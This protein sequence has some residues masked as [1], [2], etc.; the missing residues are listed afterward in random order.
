MCKIKSSQSTIPFCIDLDKL[1]KS[2][3]T[4]KLFTRIVKGGLVFGKVVF[5]GIVD[6]KVFFFE[7][8]QDFPML[9]A[10]DRDVAGCFDTKNAPLLTN[11]EIVAFFLFPKVPEMIERPALLQKN[12]CS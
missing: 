6:F 8:T 5:P 10:L 3:W 1:N 9:S 2:F 7:Q 11:C 4:A 12:I